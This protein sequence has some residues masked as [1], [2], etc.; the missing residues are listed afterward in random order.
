MKLKLIMAAGAIALLSGTAHAA[1]TLHSPHLQVAP[2]DAGM[3]QI[4]YRSARR[5]RVI[6]RRQQVYRE[7]YTPRESYVVQRGYVQDGGY[8][9]GRAYGRSYESRSYNDGRSYGDSSGY[10]VER[11]SGDYGRPSVS[12]GV[13]I[14]RD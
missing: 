8:G 14:D 7:S 3:E 13:G 1:P 11:R 5:G 10:S 6:V 4:R 12:I 9:E 2:D